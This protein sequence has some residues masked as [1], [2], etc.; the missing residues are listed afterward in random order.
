MGPA[1]TSEKAGRAASRPV[2]LMPRETGPSAL[3]PLALVAAV[4]RLARLGGERPRTQ[5]G[6]G[7]S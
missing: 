3:L 7:T 6:G 1:P 5:G 2:N 4:A